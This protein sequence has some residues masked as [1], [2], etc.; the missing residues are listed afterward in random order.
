MYSTS[1]RLSDISEVSSYTSF[2]TVS[3][4]PALT[5]VPFIDIEPVD[6][7]PFSESFSERFDYFTDLSFTGARPPNDVSYDVDRITDIQG[8]D[9][10]W[11]DDDIDEIVVISRKAKSRS[12]PRIRERKRLLDNIFSLSEFEFITQPAPEFDQARTKEITSGTYLVKL[13]R[14]TNQ[15]Y[16]ALKAFRATPSLNWP[17]E[18]RLLEM[19]T[20]QG[21][22]FLPS[23]LRRVFEHQSLFVLL[24]SKLLTSLYEHL[25]IFCRIFIPLGRCWTMYYITGS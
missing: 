16:Y 4:S 21:C 23:I 1:T 11:D 9:S 15:V 3:P 2:S 8:V 6:E 12:N 20:E 25:R 19:L 10:D 22:P 5:R 17:F 7:T 13:K 14:D 24:V 18:L